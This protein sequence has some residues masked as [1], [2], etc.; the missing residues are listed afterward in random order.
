MDFLLVRRL[1]PIT[2]RVVFRADHQSPT[3]FGSSVDGLYDVDELLLI[4][5]HPVEFVVVSRPKITHHMF[6]SEE[7]HDCHGVV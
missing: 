4:L 7:K 1:V 5:K 2:C 6:V 3:L